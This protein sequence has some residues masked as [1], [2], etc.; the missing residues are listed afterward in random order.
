MDDYKMIR[1]MGDG[2]R[3]LCEIHLQKYRQTMK[4]L[5]LFLLFFIINIYEDKGWE[6]EQNFNKVQYQNRTIGINRRAKQKSKHF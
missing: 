3:W 2:I 6:D 1:L 4:L 5:D